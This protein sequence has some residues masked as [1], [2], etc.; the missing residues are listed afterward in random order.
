MSVVTHF[1]TVLIYS[2]LFM[3]YSTISMPWS[4]QELEA[5]IA[6]RGQGVAVTQIALTVQKTTKACYAKL[7]RHS[8]EAVWT[9]LEL[10]VL[11]HGGLSLNVLQHVLQ[12]TKTRDQILAKRAK[13]DMPAKKPKVKF[14]SKERTAAA[15]Y[16]AEE[17]FM[18][19]PARSLASWKSYK[20][21][22]SG[23]F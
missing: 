3:G 2:Y 5:L 13:L 17:C 8:R 1:S 14:S 16:S 11:E 7:K 6:L 23:L 18:F 21:R 22:M 10:D 9:R 12:D 19:F 15:V 4:T 20:N